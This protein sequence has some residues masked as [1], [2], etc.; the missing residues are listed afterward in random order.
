M[1]VFLDAGR[2]RGAHMAAPGEGEG[3]GRGGERESGY[4]V[5]Q[6]RRAGEGERGRER[7]VERGMGFVSAEGGTEGEETEEFERQGGGGVRGEE[8]GEWPRW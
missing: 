7:W 2:V 5:G 6:G 8:E 3:A 1:G 4:G